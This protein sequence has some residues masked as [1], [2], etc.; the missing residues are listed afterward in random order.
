MSAPVAKEAQLRGEL[1]FDSDDSGAGVSPA[2]FDDSDDSVTGPLPGFESDSENLEEILGLNSSKA[3]SKERAA[4]SKA[5]S[6]DCAPAWK[7]EPSMEA[8]VSY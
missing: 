6:K 5:S 8:P 3:S 4:S 2:G 7:Q 1:G